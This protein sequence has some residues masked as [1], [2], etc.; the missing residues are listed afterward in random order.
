MVDR[1]ERSLP[2]AASRIPA[3]AVM[4]APST[5]VPPTG[6][7]ARLRSMLGGSPAGSQAS[8]HA[9]SLGGSS[10][11]SVTTRL[12]GTIFVIRVIGAALAYLSQILLARWMGGSEYG[13]YAYV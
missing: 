4:D 5:A 10:E 6:V 11:A 13:V 12:A 9:S 2:H 1:P 7:I 8:S 3:V